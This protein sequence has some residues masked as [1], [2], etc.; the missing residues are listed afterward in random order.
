MESKP[1]EIQDLSKAYRTGHIIRGRRPALKGLTLSV[2]KGEVFGFLG[3]N[4]SGKTTTLKVL[5]GLLRPDS[6][7]ARILGHPLD[8]MAWRYRVGYLPEHP[9]L[10]DYLTVSEYLDYAGRLFGMPRGRRDERRRELLDQV[11]LRKAARTALRRCSKGMVQRAAL[12]QSLVNDPEL[13][14]LD[15]PMSGLDP[16]GRRMV[17]DLILELKAAGKTVFFST[18]ILSD[19]EALCDRVAVLRSGELVASGALD[20]I[21]ALDVSHVEVLVAGVEAD[22]LGV[23]GVVAS[24]RSGE[25]QRLEVQERALG[26]LIR[27]V[28]EAG[29]RILSVQ[30]ARQ[31]LED[32]FFREM[33]EER[34][35]AWGD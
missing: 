17:R 29:G 26:R 22:A 7:T 12:A 1:L 11:G 35:A 8:S 2:E 9:Y 24:G 10:Y 16:L 19:A 14:L 18:H 30:P 20:Q 5:V 15:E 21:L 6:G 28:E 23:E 3:P 33:G 31:S 13:V 4:G 25:R 34:D 27:A 32:Y